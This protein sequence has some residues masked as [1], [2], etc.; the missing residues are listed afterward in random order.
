MKITYHYA[1]SKPKPQIGDR[2]V[3]KKHG[4]QIRV[5]AT[6]GGAWMRNGSRYV[7]EWRKPNELYGTQW[8]HLLTPAER[9][10]AQLKRDIEQSIFMVEST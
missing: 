5:V 1:T 8:A 6:S 9:H 3:T 10:A 2:R 7:Y 4:V